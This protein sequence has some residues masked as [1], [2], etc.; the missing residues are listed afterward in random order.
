MGVNIPSYGTEQQYTNV[1]PY[2][3]GIKTPQY[4]SQYPDLQSKYSGGGTANRNAINTGM[5]AMAG[6]GFLANPLV[7]IGITFLGGILGGLTAPKPRLS[8]EQA[9]FRDMTKFYYNVGRRSEMASS[10][11][12]AITGREVSSSVKTQDIMKRIPYPETRDG[13]K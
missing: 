4:E 11:A 3:G 9:Y 10:I 2:R 8:P 7:G 12:S 6:L 5:G 13:E 1:S